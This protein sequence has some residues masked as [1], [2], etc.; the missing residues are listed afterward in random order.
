MLYNKEPFEICWT[1]GSLEIEGLSFIWIIYVM[2]LS[3]LY[4][5][6]RKKINQVSITQFV[7]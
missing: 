3:V 7:L 6:C 4:V 5:K 1:P 2:S